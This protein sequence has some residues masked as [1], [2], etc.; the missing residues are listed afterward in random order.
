MSPYRSNSR[1][2]R[3]LINNTFEYEVGRIRKDPNGNFIIIEL[4]ISGK[5]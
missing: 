4:I 5:I 1:G 2:V 3:I